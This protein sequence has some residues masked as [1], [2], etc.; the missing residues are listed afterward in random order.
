M[1]V[2]NAPPT[3]STGDIFGRSNVGLFI[4]N[5]NY[6]NALADRY[7]PPLHFPIAFPQVFLRDLPGFDVI[8]GN[9]PWEE[10]TLEVD[11]F[12]ARHAPGLQALSQREQ[13]AMKKRFQRHYLQTCSR[14]ANNLESG[15]QPPFLIKRI[16]QES[17]SLTS[18]I[19]RVL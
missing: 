2:Y 8:L 7:I 11:R 10:A 13:E 4:D 15:L 16:S 6:F 5:D 12:W 19:R 18:P 17:F 9:P 3:Y 1:D 14:S